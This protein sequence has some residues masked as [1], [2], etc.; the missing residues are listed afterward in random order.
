MIC[1][2][3]GFAGE[4]TP[5]RL[6]EMLDFEDAVLIDVRPDDLRKVRDGIISHGIACVC[7]GDCT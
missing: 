1:R 3:G 5:A 4:V 7:G 2:Y 6:K